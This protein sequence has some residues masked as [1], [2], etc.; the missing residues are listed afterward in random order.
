MVNISLDASNATMS[1]MMM[2]VAI[3]RNITESV[4]NFC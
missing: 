1:M 4:L 2:M 3:H